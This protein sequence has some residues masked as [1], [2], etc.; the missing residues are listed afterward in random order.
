LLVM[1]LRFDDGSLGT[2]MT[3]RRTPDYEG[4][5]AIVYGSEGKAGVHEGIGMV[6]GGTLDVSTSTTVES[7]S[8]ENDSIALYT[9][10]VDGFSTAVVSGG[11][12]VASGLDGLRAVQITLAMTES[13]R[14]GHRV[15]IQ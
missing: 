9:W 15:N 14:T 4:N 8:Y 11:E 5:D 7:E 12:P 3:G 6:L 1:S 10:Q 13:S 2:V